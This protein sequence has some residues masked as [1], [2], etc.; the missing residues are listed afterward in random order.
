MNNYIKCPYLCPSEGCFSMVFPTPKKKTVPP[1][2]ATSEVDSLDV[3]QALDRCP[4]HPM[5]M[6]RYLKHPGG[7]QQNNNTTIGFIWIYDMDLF[8]FISYTADLDGQDLDQ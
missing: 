8:V 4:L 7:L 5:K 1:G 3:F 2:L 6:V